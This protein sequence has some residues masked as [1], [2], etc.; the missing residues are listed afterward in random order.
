M[1]KMTF[2]ITG[3]NTGIG[4]A[5]A[6]E[7]ARKNQKVVLVCRDNQKGLAA[8]EEI[9]SSSENCE[10]ELV[11]GDLSSIKSC[12]NLAGVLV[13]KYPDMNVLINNAGVWKTK[14]ELNSDGLESTFMVNHMAPFILSNLLFPQLQKN[15]HARIVNVNAGLY[16]KGKLDLEKTPYGKDFTRFGTYANT[17]LCNVLTTCEMARRIEGSGVTVNAVHPGVINTGLGNSPGLLGFVLR[18]AKHFW[19]TPAQGAV[20]PVWLA[21]DPSLHNTSGKFF[22]LKNEMELT[23][24][25]KDTALAKRLW[26][27]SAKTAGI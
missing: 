21:T 27:F 12:T 24:A 13:E 22:L 26:E 9:Q 14:C 1:D 2:I 16:I 4:K 19:G 18:G 6:F 8:L 15:A 10:T 3:A 5:I 20:A 17:K 11:Q 7:L 25:A 23:D